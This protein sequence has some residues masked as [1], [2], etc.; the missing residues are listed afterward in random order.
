MTCMPIMK[1]FKSGRFFPVAE[2]GGGLS[3]IV[4]LLD[5]SGSETKLNFQKMLNFVQDFT[6]Q[7]DIGPKNAQIGVAT[8][9]SDVHE[10]IKLDQ[11]RCVIHRRF[12]VSL[13]IYMCCL[14]IQCSY[15]QQTIRIYYIITLFVLLNFKRRTII[16]S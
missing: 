8:F 9:S 16:V 15:I 10:R 11:Y 13:Y 3:D 6:R 1:Q 7:F 4:F 5:S 14:I 2:C 12:S